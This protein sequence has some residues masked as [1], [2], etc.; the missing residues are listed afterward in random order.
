LTEAGGA[1]LAVVSAASGC[2]LGSDGLP[3][4]A[5]EALADGLRFGAAVFFGADLFLGAL[6]FLGVD[7]FAGADFLVAAPAC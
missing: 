4:A 5:A 7:F 3:D 1:V 2:G 6:C